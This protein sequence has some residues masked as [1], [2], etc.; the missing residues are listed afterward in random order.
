MASH[1]QKT[2]RAFRL[3]HER[4]AALGVNVD[5]ALKALERIPVSLHCWQGDDVGGFE[6]LSNNLLLHMQQKV[7]SPNSAAASP[8]RVITPAKH[9][10]RMSCE[11]TWRK[12]SRSSPANIA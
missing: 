3:A 5:R 12:L 11:W 4:Y 2:E 6:K 10:R 8:S 9:A 1:A 7:H